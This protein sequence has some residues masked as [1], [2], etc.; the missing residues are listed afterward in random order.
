MNVDESQD[1]VFNDHGT[2]KVN[3]TDICCIKFDCVF[4]KITEE[5]YNLQLTSMKGNNQFDIIKTNEGFSIC[6]EE[7]NIFVPSALKVVLAP[8]T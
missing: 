3:A 8:P 7:D 5:D 1:V 2:V 6:S 4:N